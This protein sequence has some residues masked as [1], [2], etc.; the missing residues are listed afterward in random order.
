MSQFV[1]WIA[2]V[3]D[4]E[5]PTTGMPGIPPKMPAENKNARREISQKQDFAKTDFSK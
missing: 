4:G 1:S 3:A 5:Y 2:A